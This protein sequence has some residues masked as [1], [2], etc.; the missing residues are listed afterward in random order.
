MQGATDYAKQQADIFKQSLQYLIDQENEQKKNAQ[1]LATQN[2]E[3]IIN[4]LNQNKIP[5][6][7]QYQE[8]ARQAYVNKVLA[9]KKLESDLTRLGLDT[10]GFAL[11]QKIYN[12]NQYSSNLNKLALDKAAG[13]RDIENDITNARGQLASDLLGLEVDYGDRLTKLNQYITEQVD[14]KYNDAYNIF[15][16]NKQYEDKLKQQEWENQMAE[17]QYNDAL[18]QQAIENQ[19]NWYKIYN[20]GTGSDNKFNGSNNETKPS[21]SAQSPDGVTHVRAMGTVTAAKDLGFDIT[22]LPTNQSIHEYKDSKGNLYYLVYSPDDKS[23][24]DITEEFKKFQ[25]KLKAQKY[26]VTLNDNPALNVSKPQANVS[27]PSQNV[28]KPNVNVSKP[29]QNVSKPNV[30]NYVK[31]SLTGTT[32]NFLKNILNKMYTGR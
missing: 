13:L 21:D 24:I 11:T 6:E 27:K 31:S 5:I 23:Y 3:N 18:K 22:G 15:F 29:S 9:G 30:N 26:G 25:E 16:T 19:Q 17:K 10:T 4:Q 12:E 14:Q 20:S 32:N 1:Q 7:A 28:S 8:N 2:Y